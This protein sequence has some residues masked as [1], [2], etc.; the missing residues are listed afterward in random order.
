MSESP[1]FTS[2]AMSLPVLLVLIPLSDARL[3]A[4]ESDFDVIL[5]P[6]AARRAQ[7][8]AEH[9]A[10]VR[11]VLTNGSTGLTAAEIDAMPGLTLASALGAGYENIDVAHARARGIVLVNGAG[12]NDQCVADHA[13]GLLLAIVRGLP[14]LDRACRDG[15]WRT[16][17]RPPPNVS[18]KRLGLLGL[19]NIGR[20][21]ARRGLGFD[22]T[23]GYHARSPRQDVDYRYFDD[24]RALAAWSDYLVVATPGGGDTRHLVDA[25][26]L[27]ALGPQGFLVNIARG[28]VVDT[29]ALADALRDARIA[30]AGLD[31]YESEPRPP[32]ELLAFP[33][34]LLTPHVAGWSPEAIEASMRQFIDNARRHLAGEPVLTPI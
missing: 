11:L 27:D 1:G 8:V 16:S 5:A 28:S 20:R 3:S 2:P 21:I 13:F 9:G 32:A 34:V 33:N 26:V 14:Q 23:I 7:A 25:A 18:G 15:V 29:A 17:L 19:G 4:L 12:T 30:G 24:A 31:V 10:R 22:M 6:D